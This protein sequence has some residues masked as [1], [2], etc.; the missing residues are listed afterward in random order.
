MTSLNIMINILGNPTLLIAAKTL[1]IIIGSM[2]MGIWLSYLYYA[3]YKNQL[4][5]ISRQLEQEYNKSQRLREELQE[6][7]DEN[8]ARVYQMDELKSKLATLSREIQTWQEQVRTSE[9]ES[10]KL[11]EQS[12]HLRIVNESLHQRLRVIEEELRQAVAKTGRSTAKQ[13][14]VAATRANYEQVSQ[15]LG[16]TVAENDLTIILGLGPKTSILLQEKGIDTWEKLAGVPVEDLQ[17]WLQEAGGVYKTINPTHWPR[18]AK[19]AALGEW[20]KL[21]IYQEKIRNDMT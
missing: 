20:R 3:R 16:R 21:R 7:K 12:D 14:V 6:Q 5:G 13:P 1:V 19:M 15:V 10:H 9:N 4:A 11:K 18:Q 2:L 8:T 17:Q